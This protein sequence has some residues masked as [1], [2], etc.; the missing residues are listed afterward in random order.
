[1]AAVTANDTGTPAGSGVTVTSVAAEPLVVATTEPLLAVTTYDA[2]SG[3]LAPATPVHDTCT[4]WTPGVPATLVG[5][6]SWPPGGTDCGHSVHT[7]LLHAAAVATGMVIASFDTSR[8]LH[9]TTQ[10]GSR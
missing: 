4:N 9:T 8:L 6:G 2:T 10:H 5:A 1:M 3:R 7:L